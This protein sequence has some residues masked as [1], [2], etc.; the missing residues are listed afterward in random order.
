MKPGV[1]NGG[2]QSPLTCIDFC[3]YKTERIGWTT[4]M[5]GLHNLR[6]F[7]IDKAKK[8]YD[9]RVVNYANDP[10]SKLREMFVH[11]FDQNPVELWG[12]DVL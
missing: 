10:W 8:C 11:S 6:K 5:D 9:L 2:S 12:F 3:E 4:D 7:F 1:F